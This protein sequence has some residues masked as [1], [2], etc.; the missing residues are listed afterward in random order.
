[1]ASHVKLPS[2]NYQCISRYTNPLTGKRTKITLTYSGNTRKAQRNAERELEDKIDQ[3]IEQYEQVKSEEVLRFSQ[4]VEKWFEYWCVGVNK[5][6]VEREKLVIRRVKQ[7]IDGDVLIQNMT[8][9]LLEKLLTDYQQ[10]YDS[11]YSTMIHIKCTLNKIFKY[12]VKHRIMMYSPMS[13]VEL[14][15]PREKKMEPKIRRKMK[16][17]EPYELNAFLTEVKKTTNPVYYHLT[18]FLVNTG[19]RIGEAG[20]LT[21]DDIDFKNRRLK[22][23]KS[24]IQIGKGQFE[25]GPPK[26]EE[27]ERVVGLSVV[28]VRSL[29]AA[30]EKS[31]Q[32]DKRYQLKPWKSY[33][34]TDSIFRTLNGAPVTSKS[35][36]TFIH[37]VQKNLRETCEVKYGFKWV[38]NITPHS[39][40]FIN[41]TYLKDSEGVDPKSIQS[42]VGHTD[43]RTTMNIYAQTSMKETDRIVTALDH[44]LDKDNPLEFYPE[45][46]CSEYSTKLNKVL[47]KNIDK[48]VL[49]F[50]LDE[51]RELLEIPDNYETRHIK[52]NI[53][54]KLVNDLSEEWQRFHIETIYGKM[55]RIL[56]YKIT[57]GE[58]KLLKGKR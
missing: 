49:E 11:S 14:N 29:L 39:F 2:G 23:T 42:H 19:L 8:P 32:L 6:T 36:R 47:R 15:L 31:D 54:K 58:N 21:R 4:L 33:I 25:Y 50:S 48:N 5:R 26:T 10:E 40:R 24:L 20:A 41:I 12:A 9:L 13:S 35:Y 53:V 51:F 55:R 52:N 7:L 46:F 37:R 43:L 28:A 57:Y 30:I 3:I 44:W 27:S 45:V 17:L 34:K 56:G 16:Y 22:V 18:L 1:M 38:K